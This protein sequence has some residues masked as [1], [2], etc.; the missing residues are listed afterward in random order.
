LTAEKPDRPFKDILLIGFAAAF[1]Q[2]GVSTDAKKIE[3]IAY[4]HS[5]IDANTDVPDDL[6][7]LWERYKLAIFMNS[8][9]NQLIG[10]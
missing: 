8:D 6:R 2:H 3:R 4:V 9:L 1:R 5:I 10:D 7:R